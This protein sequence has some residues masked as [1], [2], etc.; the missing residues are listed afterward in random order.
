MNPLQIKAS[1]PEMG[2]WVS[3]SAGTGKTK[4]LTDR[5][6]RLLLKGVDPKKILCLTFTNAAASEMSERIIS[7]LEQLAIGSD[8][9]IR[10]ALCNITGKLPNN[11]EIEGA[12][13]LYKEYLS[14]N[15]QLNIHT[16]HSYCQKILQQF[17]I[18]A[19]I[20]PSFLILD[21]SNQQYAMAFIRK[22]ILAKPN[23]SKI[24]N[25]LAANFHQLTIDEIFT[26]MLK[27]KAKFLSHKTPSDAQ[28]ATQSD[29]LEEDNLEDKLKEDRLDDELYDNPDKIVD[30]LLNGVDHIYESIL[31]YPLILN[32]IDVKPTISQLKKFFLIKNGQKKKRIV[33]AKI[34]KP[35]SNTY[36]ELLLL[37]DKLYELDQL[38]RSH[39]VENYSKLLRL[40]AKGYLSQY[41]EYKK[42]HNLLDYDDLI[43]KAKALLCDKTARQ[44]VLYKLDGGIDHILVDEAQDTSPDQWQIIEAL[45]HEFF[46]GH[47]KDRDERTI[48]V[49][50]DEKQSIFS[51]QGADID[52]FINMNKLLTYKLSQAQR[53]FKNINLDISYRSA[54]E[55]LDVAHEV[56]SSLNRDNTSLTNA[57]AIFAKMP[58]IQAH[59]SSH[60]GKVELWPL[61]HEEE[62]DQ[63][64][65][66]IT[67]DSDKFQSSKVRLANNIAT[68]I[69]NEIDSGRILPATGKRISAADFMIL[70][71]SRSELTLNI[72]DEIKNLSLPVSG[73]DRVILTDDLIVKDLIAMAKFVL[74][75]EDKLNL[76][77][78][79]NSPIFNLK[80]NT[81]DSSALLDKI[82]HPA[83]D[84]L[85]KIY[86]NSNATKF[87]H[88]VCHQF[89]IRIIAQKSY[90][91]DSLESI[92]ELLK[93]INKYTKNNDYSLQGFIDW[94]EMDQTEI[95]KNVDNLDMIKIMTVHGA[96][97]LQA[98]YVIL[99]DTSSVP[100]STDRFLWCDKRGMLS[101][102]DSSFV[103][104]SFTN[105]KDIV[106]NKQYQEYLRLFYV[107]MTRAQDN[108][109]ICGHSGKKTV[110]EN[111]WYELAKVA[112]EKIGTK[113]DDGRIIYENKD[114]KYLPDDTD[115][116][117]NIITPAS[118]IEFIT[119]SFITQSNI[120][121]DND[122]NN[123]S[124]GAGKGENEIDAGRYI[125]PFSKNDSM[126]YGLVFHKLL[127][128]SVRL[129]KLNEMKSHPLISTL[130]NMQQ[131]KILKSI[132]LITNNNEFIDLLSKDI[133][134]EVSLGTHCDKNPIIGRID[135]LIKDGDYLK[136]IDYKS[137]RNPAKTESDVAQLYI[138]QLKFYY[139]ILAKLYPN[140]IVKTY[141]LWLEN[142]QLMECF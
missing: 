135:L 50:G 75:P 6:V 47:N 98:P 53:N 87:F 134:T 76:A 38:E 123:N 91:F 133:K 139:K 68:Y 40:L 49:V 11:R 5:V 130:D 39:Q 127:E 79:L 118:N 83:L 10:D 27:N 16:I 107:A 131:Q 142:G 100:A 35:G 3:A 115:D 64:F 57:H 24:S 99:C 14:N 140:S 36:D 4:I 124:T 71:R 92:N 26:G 103:P 17:P 32:L 67:S 77:S 102:I 82:D 52:S 86:K 1:D 33:S 95:K 119:P 125:S 59:R 116:T 80:I 141:I 9:E 85:T 121:D 74:N 129:K 113:R 56:F 13:N 55:I 78:L 48:F 51:F 62:K 21:E 97:G 30:N 94:F 28:N 101:A 120:N 90:G 104:T 138:Q 54:K 110:P 31:Q 41:E 23:Y 117:S 37:Q 108:L 89:N 132:E 20:S 122:N 73:L 106:Q 58:D 29:E 34:A 112:L 8:N 96:K 44:W 61:I 66:H 105:L 81:L 45:I 70:F 69:K 88:N 111:C 19:D 109:L 12:K 63:Q 137:D 136:I 18:E 42:N 46:A 7:K 128:D 60:P 25:F 126:G 43:G 15:N 93:L 84:K 2:V 22:E 65:W 114:K 72:I